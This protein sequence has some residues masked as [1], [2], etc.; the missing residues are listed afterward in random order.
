VKSEQNA[1]GEASD[2]PRKVRTC[3]KLAGC[4]KSD[5]QRDQHDAAKLERLRTEA[6]LGF[7]ALDRGEFSTKSL[8]QI[9]QEALTRHRKEQRE[10]DGNS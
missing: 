8:E 6:A 9:V 10:A 1:E 2:E 3:K 5:I 7:G 4:L